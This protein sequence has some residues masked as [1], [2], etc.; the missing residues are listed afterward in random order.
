MTWTTIFVRFLRRV[1]K[2]IFLNENIMLKGA[3]LS[4]TEITKHD[5]IAIRART[6][7]DVLAFD[8]TVHDVE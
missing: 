4:N 7:E 6:E 1:I 8:V 2:L 5:F 3:N